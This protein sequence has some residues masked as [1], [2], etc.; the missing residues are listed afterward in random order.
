MHKLLIITTGCMAALASG[1]RLQASAVNFQDPNDWAVGDSGS[2]FQEWDARPL[3]F[4][5]DPNAFIFSTRSTSPSAMTASPALT[6]DPNLSVLSPGFVGS[7][8]GYYSFSGDYGVYADILNHGGIAGTGGLYDASFGTRVIVQTAATVNEDPNVGGPASIF[9]ETLELVDPNGASLQGGGNSDALHIL[10]VSDPNLLVDS[11]FGLVHQQE[12]FFEFWL[13]GFTGDFR[14][15]T[16]S[17]VHSSFQ[18]LRVDTLIVQA[19][20]DADFNGDQRVDGIDLLM[21]QNDPTSSGGSAGL[22]AWE[23]QYGETSGLAQAQTLVPEPSTL[24]LVMLGLLAIGRPSR[25]TDS[26]H[27]PLQ[28]KRP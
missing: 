15:Q 10:E 3:E 22:T 27:E 1:Q 26:Y 2:T 12:Y 28:E 5:G 14:V 8:G 25:R 9:A 4:L 7:S 24:M 17:I 13:P 6:D 16:G 11:P 18:H 21:W 20:L 19:G 23:T